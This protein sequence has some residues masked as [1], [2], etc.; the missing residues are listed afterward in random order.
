MYLM[1][2][3]SAISAII[4][5]VS[6]IVKYCKKLKYHRKIVLITNGLSFID[7]EDV[8]QITSKIKQDNMELVVLS[9]W[10]IYE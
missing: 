7:A 8:T 1:S 3:C 10:G 6:M 9:V 2:F 4:I 5:A